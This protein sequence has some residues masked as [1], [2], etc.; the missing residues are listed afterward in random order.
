MSWLD[1]LHKKNLDTGGDELTELTK[2]PSVSFVSAQGAVSEF[3]A[4]Q[5]GDLRNADAVHGIPIAELRTLAG[6]DW[7]DCERDPAL[8]KTFAHAVEIRK[9]RERGEIPPHYTQRCTCAR[10]GPVWLWP[11]APDYVQGCP[12]C[13][14]R[15][16]GRRVPRR[17]A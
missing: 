3:V 10:C 1:R 2:A 6:A 15:A 14:N 8:L 7:P 4:G 9:M 17:A 16:A 13:L 5:T 12:W 11:G